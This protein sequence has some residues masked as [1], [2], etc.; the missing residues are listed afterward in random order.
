[1]ATPYSPSSGEYAAAL[2][3]L[4]AKEAMRYLDEDARA[5]ARVGLEANTTAMLEIDE[6]RKRVVDDLMR[7]H[8]LEVCQRPDTARIMLELA[9]VQRRICTR[10]PPGPICHLSLHAHTS[11]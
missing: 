5:I 7:A 4:F 9:A 1:M 8:A 6:N 2:L 10:T 3:R 11:S